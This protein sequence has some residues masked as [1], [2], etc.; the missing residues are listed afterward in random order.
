MLLNLCQSRASVRAY[1][2]QLPKTE[3][4]EYI[5]ECVRLAP[6]A[7]NRQPWRIFYVTAQPLLEKLRATY[8]REWFATAPAVFVLCKDEEAQWVRP[9]DHRPH[10]DIDLAIATEHLCLAA[11]EQGLG[12]CWVCNFDVE[13]CRQALESDARF[14][15]VAMIPIGYAAPEHNDKGRHRKAM[16][17]ILEFR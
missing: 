15:P 13:A 16:E 8:P 17:D 14:T 10:G 6:S 9:Q 2:P 3:A 7:V 12:T 5:C 11:T 4:I 1:L